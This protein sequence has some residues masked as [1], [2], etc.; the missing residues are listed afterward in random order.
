MSRRIYSACTLPA[1]LQLFPDAGHGLCYI[2]DPKLYER[3]CIR[4]LW[5]I[6]ELKPYLKGN[7]YVEMELN[8][9]G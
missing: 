3:A 2:R 8:D 5:R 1:Q 4:F 9:H 7:E 6:D